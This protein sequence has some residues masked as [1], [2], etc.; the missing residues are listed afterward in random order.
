MSWQA[1]LNAEVEAARE[2]AKERPQPWWIVFDELP[3]GVFA[4]GTDRIVVART[5]YGMRV[6]VRP[7]PTDRPECEFYALDGVE[8]LAVDEED[9]HA[10]MRCV[11]LTGLHGT[12]R[13]AGIPREDPEYREYRF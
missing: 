12:Y 7:A 10:V 3:Q 13:K 5:L 8:R 4:E 1:D 2:R 6:P 11:R 9:M